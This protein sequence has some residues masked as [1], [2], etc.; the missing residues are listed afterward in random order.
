M[1][2]VRRCLDWLHQ[3]DAAGDLVGDET[4]QL[5]GR[6]DDGGSV[7]RHLGR[8]QHEMDVGRVVP[9]A[10]HAHGRIGRRQIF[11]I[12][13]DRRLV[14][15][16]R[17]KIAPDPVVDVARHVHEVAGA[18]NGPPQPV[19][20]GLGALRPVRRLHRVDVIVHRARM[21]RVAGQ[22]A[23]ERR[24]DG[25][26]GRHVNAG[27]IDLVGGVARQGREGGP[28]TARCRLCVERNV[29]C[30]WPPW[31]SA[32]SI[33]FASRPRRPYGPPDHEHAGETFSPSPHSDSQ[34][35]AGKPTL[36]CEIS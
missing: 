19:R 28:G 31:I 29:S 14:V 4:A 36:A 10:I 26:A 9:E 30:S 33:S 21:A 6:R 32:R 23:F 7:A 12:H 8:R 2:E 17:V 5:L 27:K 22:H 25:A 20:I 34:T 35:S 15:G 11:F 16:Q 3:R 13:P 18:G 24:H 1:G